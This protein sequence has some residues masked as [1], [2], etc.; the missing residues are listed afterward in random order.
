M[1]GSNMAP[2]SRAILVLCPS[3]RDRRELL[4]LYPGREYR[5]IFHDYATADLERMVSPSP[6][7]SQVRDP[8]DEIDAIVAA[9]A[10]TRLDGV[11][12]TDDYPGSA[13]ASIVARRMNLAGTQPRANL[14]CQHKY[15]SR[16]AQRAVCGIAVPNFELLANGRLYDVGYPCFLK[17]VKSFFS[18]GASRV[19]NSR[20]LK[21]LARRA[22]LPEPFFSPFKALFERYTDLP[23]GPH[24]VLG[25]DLLEGQQ[26]TLEG[27]AFAGSVKTIGIVDSVVFRG[28]LAFERFEYPSRLPDT[29][30]ARMTKIA[31]LVMKQIGFDHGL[32]NIELMYNPER[33]LIH[34]IEIN[35]RMASQFAD[36]HEKVDGFNTYAVLVDLALNTVPQTRHRAGKYSVAASCVLRRFRDAM[37]LRAPAP[38]DVA[39]LQTSVPDVRV[40][41]LATAGTQLSRKM[42]D[43]CSYRYGMVNIGGRDLPEVLAIFDYCKRALPFVFMDS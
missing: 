11:I 40:E 25:E 20:S 4:A 24:R 19:E 37:V 18:I 41:V 32:F 43:G 3:D 36:L 9:H 1:R 21:A 17:P 35:P 33:D 2:I 26:V 23:F 38:N 42:Q 5:F 7:L 6:C 28:T 22:T 13:L 39:Q 14:I 8:D 27:Y 12:S 15:Y 30:Q 16:V 10:G 34:I 31:P 29:V